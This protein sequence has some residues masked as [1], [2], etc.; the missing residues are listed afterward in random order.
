M[1]ERKKRISTRKARVSTRKAGISK[2]EAD[3]IGEKDRK[4]PVLVSE[5]APMRTGSYVGRV[6][7][8]CDEETVRILVEAKRKGLPNSACAALA[9][10]TSRML[11]AWIERG[12]EDV[13]EG[14]VASEFAVFFHAFEYARGERMAEAIG[15]IDEQSKSNWQAGA[16][17]LERTEAQ[18]FSPIS[19][20]YVL[21]ADAASRDDGKVTVV[22]DLKE[23]SVPVVDHAAKEDDGTEDARKDVASPVVDATFV[24]KTR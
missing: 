20:G 7:S 17:L 6:L 13:E 1:A 12:M 23:Q 16:W 9:G 15:R 14:N 21:T 11:S 10:I 2:A 18:D 22:S 8:V 19:R 24:P 4:R 3:L 5:R